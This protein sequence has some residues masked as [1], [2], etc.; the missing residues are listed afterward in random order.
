MSKEKEFF[1]RIKKYIVA[2][3]EKEFG[4]AHKAGID[5]IAVITTGNDKL[6]LVKMEIK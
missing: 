2:E 6:V 1:D 5:E 4:Y 3:G